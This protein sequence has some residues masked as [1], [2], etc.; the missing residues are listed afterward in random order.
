[1]VTAGAQLRVGSAPGRG[2][3]LPLRILYDSDEC[4]AVDKPAGMPTSATREAAGGTVMEVLQQQMRAAGRR[5]RLWLVHRLDAAT[6]GV[7]LFATT[8]AQA[9]RLSD[10]FASGGVEKRYTALV[11]GSPP[12]KRGTI[13]LSILG[14]GRRVRCDPAGKPAETEWQ[15]LERRGATTLLE[16]V[17]RTGRM[18][19]L[20]VHLQGVGLPIVGDRWYGGVPAARLMLHASALRLRQ[21]D[22]T[23][24]EVVAPLP[25][26]LQTTI[27]PA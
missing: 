15:V 20:R 10:L 23:V 7:L 14:A 13:R 6:S 17:P 9:V 11:G 26:A 1:M 18:H 16:L 3:V 21:R 22:G 4:L 25:A 2:S 12:E 5:E 27:T 24:L 8:R 19:Q